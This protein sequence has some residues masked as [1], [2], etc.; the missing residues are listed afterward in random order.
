MRPSLP[1]IRLRMFAWC[2]VDDEAGD[3]GNSDKALIE[4][5]AEGRVERGENGGHHRCERRIA[6]EECNDQPR[7]A[8]RQRQPRIERDDDAGGGR[9]ALAALESEEHRVQVAEEHRDAGKRDA[10]VADAEA[11]RSAAPARPQTS[12]SA[13]RRPASARRPTLLPERRTLVAPGFFEP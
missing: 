3:D 8:R 6:E 4:A 5:P 1:A 9:H 12:P 13:H 10:P 7:Y 2:R 11:R